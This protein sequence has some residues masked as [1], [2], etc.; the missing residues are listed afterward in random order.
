MIFGEVLDGAE[1][2]RVGLV[3]RCVDDDQLL[4]AAHEMAARAA[5]APRELVIEVK[6]TIQAMAD[7]RTHPEAVEARAQAAGVEHPAAVVRRA[8]RGAAGEDRPTQ[9]A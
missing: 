6:K 9:G 8:D 3:H 7:V 4:A 2:E 5:S 1:A